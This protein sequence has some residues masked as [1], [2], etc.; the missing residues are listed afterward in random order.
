MPVPFPSTA[1]LPTLTLKPWPDEVID[2]LGHHPTSAYV[3]T[4]WLGILG[5]SATWLLRHLVATIESADRSTPPLLELANTARR[6]GLG[7]RNGPHSPFVRTIG[8]LVRFQL[9]QMEDATTLAVRLRVPPLNRNQQQRL[10]EVLQRA[11]EAWQT[12]QLRIPEVERQRMRA[13]HLALSYLEARLGVDETEQQLMRL[14]YH[15]AI[16]HDAVRWAVDRHH[17]ALAAAKDAPTAAAP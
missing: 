6:L 3:E 13:R 17:R 4:F 5:P 15:P 1:D 14:H 11:H 16:C 9:A 8:R 2:R 7:D 10:P 12:D